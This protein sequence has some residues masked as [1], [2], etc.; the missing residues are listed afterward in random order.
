MLA[1]AVLA[2]A[3]FLV[4]RYTPHRTADLAITHTALYQAHTVFKSDTILIKKDNAQDDLCVLLT[5]RVDD[6]L[7]LPLFLKDMAATFT[8]AKGESLTTSAAEKRDLPAILNTFPNLKSLASTPLLR[9]TQIAP[10]Q[11]AAGMVLLQFPITQDVWN[12]RQS[13]TLTVDSTT[14]RHKP[15]PSRRRSPLLYTLFHAL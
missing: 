15:S 2:V 13:A 14:N 5:L 1:I 11:S 12:H 7:N 6:K 3:G 8:D 9:D 4:V 10:G